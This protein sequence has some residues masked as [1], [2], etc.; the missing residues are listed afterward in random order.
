MSQNQHR[1][2]A[3]TPLWLALS[4]AWTDANADALR[5]RIEACMKNRDDAA[6]LQCFDALANSMPA[7]KP[8][9]ESPA[10]TQGL[11]RPPPPKVSQTAKIASVSQPDGR[12]YRV[13]LDNEQV[14]Q[15]T[16]HTRDLDLEAGQTVHIKPG[17][18]GSYFLKLDSG[19]STRVRRVR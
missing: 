3:L 15:E 12:K 11:R 7:E 13:V 16:E 9:T 19:L 5:E 17:V 18:L 6:R 10:D 14:W 4:L 1:F 2:I 8:A